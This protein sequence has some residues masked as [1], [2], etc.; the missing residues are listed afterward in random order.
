MNPVRRQIAGGNCRLGRVR[1]VAIVAVLLILA[2]CGP[3]A[4]AGG[5]AAP[6]ISSLIAVNARQALPPLMGNTLDG[7]TY[8]ASALAGRIVV[9]NVW[10]SWCPPCRAEAPTLRALS[11]EFQAA[12]VQ[13]VGID[14]KDTR[15]AARSFERRF[16]IPYPSMF[17][18]SGELLLNFRGTV[19][20]S[21]IPSTVLIDRQGRVA[22]RIVGPT[23]YSQ[24]KALL[25]SLVGE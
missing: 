24:L 18:P 13:F 14:V 4:V 11:A 20:P 6:G 21:A 19:P 23:T 3:G 25:N 5:E 1:L 2:G 17:D 7:A 9:Y 10:G 16:A 12:G 22:A 15:S 8:N